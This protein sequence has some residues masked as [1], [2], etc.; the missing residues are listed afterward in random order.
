M[1]QSKKNIKSNAKKILSIGYLIIGIIFQ[2]NLY[3]V[4]DKYIISNFIKNRKYANCH[5]KTLMNKGLIKKLSIQMLNDNDVL[6]TYIVYEISPL[7]QNAI[8]FY[9]EFKKFYKSKNIIQQLLD[10]YTFDT[11]E[12]EQIGLIQED[13]RLQDI[14]GKGLYTNPIA[15]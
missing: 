6:E 10:N 14:R 9:Q 12:L 7:E 4:N 13:L 2:S 5:V 11:S 3:A 1:I 15:N 8:N